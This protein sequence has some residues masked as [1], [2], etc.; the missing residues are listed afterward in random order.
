MIDDVLNNARRLQAALDAG[1]QVTVLPGPSAV[2]TALVASGL[3][4]E[5]YQF[6]GFLPR[7]AS[8]LD[9]V[10]EDLRRAESATVAFESPTCGMRSFSQS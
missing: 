5:R 2:E 3:V 4:G 8:A 10:W 6:V 9:A 7:G 1:V